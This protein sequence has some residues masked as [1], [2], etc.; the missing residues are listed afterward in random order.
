MEHLQLISL[1]IRLVGAITNNPAL[2]GGSG[3]RTDQISEV[4]GK[5]AT[6]VNLGE[7]AGAELKVFTAQ[8]QI[9]ADEGRSPSPAEWGVLMARSDA[10]H[11][12][13]QAVKEKIT[14]NDNGSKKKRSSKKKVSKKSN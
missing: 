4:L 10:A 6:L 8:V 1:A 5:L 2:G 13:L 9:L 12:R 11:G 3:M 7:S 14:G